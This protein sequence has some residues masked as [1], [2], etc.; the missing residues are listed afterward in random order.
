M[1]TLALAPRR[2]PARGSMRPHDQMRQIVCAFDEDTFAE[3][4]TIAAANRISFRAAVRLLVEHGIED[5]K[6][7]SL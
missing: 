4:N 5:E 3:I 2:P 6:V 1:T 7:A